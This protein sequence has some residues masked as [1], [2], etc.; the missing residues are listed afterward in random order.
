MAEEFD[1]IPAD[2]GTN[3][4]EALP[5]EAKFLS[6]SPPPPVA[7]N[8]S[9]QLRMSQ[10]IS[11][12]IVE[13]ADIDGIT[14]D[15]A[16]LDH[17]PE[18]DVKV[19]VSPIAIHQ[20]AEEKSQLEDS[21]I[22]QE[23]SGAEFGDFKEAE[24]NWGEFK[25]SSSST[26]GSVELSELIEKLTD[27]EVVQR[28]FRNL[29]PQVNEEQ[30]DSDELDGVERLEKLV[31]RLLAEA[32][33][34]QGKLLFSNVSEPLK[35]FEKEHFKWGQSFVEQY[36]FRSMG[37]VP[38]SERL[39]SSIFETK[40]SFAHRSSLVSFDRDKLEDLK[41]IAEGN[42][43]DSTEI[44]S[45]ESLRSA[46]AGASGNVQVLGIDSSPLILIQPE[47]ARLSMHIQKQNSIELLDDAIA[48]YAKQVKRITEVKD[49]EK[50][51]QEDRIAHPSDVD[52]M[53]NH[54]QSP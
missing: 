16:T 37:I 15:G 8:P 50:K 52:Y 9:P 40:S 32:G 33:G 29:F 3:S 2:L 21:S 46:A 6:Q 26:S 14:E 10:E 36:M 48:D 35:L 7:V 34:E 53:V 1:D 19:I 39:D 22:P 13:E 24:E 31:S 25:E 18:L 45:W 20:D 42:L 12:D 54:I 30:K 23:K 5:E 38:P 47:V 27:L 41:D 43:K 11:G 17:Q 28:A 4:F 49:A 51:E 44:Q